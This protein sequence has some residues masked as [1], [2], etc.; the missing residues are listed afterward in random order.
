MDE[1]VIE[2]QALAYPWSELEAFGLGV[3]VNL[4]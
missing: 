1:V 4:Q 2:M 3:L